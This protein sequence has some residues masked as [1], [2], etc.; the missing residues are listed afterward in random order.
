MVGD[1]LAK[2][3]QLAS[4]PYPPP[5]QPTTRNSKNLSKIQ[6]NLFRIVDGK[7]LK[8]IP[9]LQHSLGRGPQGSQ[10]CIGTWPV[11]NDSNILIET[12]PGKGSSRNLLANQISARSGNLFLA[13]FSTA[14]EVS[15]SLLG[16]IHV[17]GPSHG[18]EKQGKH[19][20]KGGVECLHAGSTCSK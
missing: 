10:N 2:T 7:A 18:H 16:V 8:G 11:L 5:P 12:R 1:L 14:A 20:L 15:D 19:G 9:Q 3:G 13:N 6:A 4:S 17:P